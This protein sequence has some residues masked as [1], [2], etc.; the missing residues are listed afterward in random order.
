MLAHT[1]GS[2]LGNSRLAIANRWH[3]RP[4]AASATGQSNC[5]ISAKWSTTLLCRFPCDYMAAAVQDMCLF[6][7]LTNCAV[8]I[9]PQGHLSE[10]QVSQPGTY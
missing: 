1:L 2:T 5:K 10:I 9:N 7:G 3:H 4:G 8:D 6:D